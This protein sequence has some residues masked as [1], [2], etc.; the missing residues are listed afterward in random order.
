MGSSPTSKK[1]L[2]KETAKRNA[3]RK[4]HEAVAA[5]ALSD[6][7]DVVFEAGVKF[8]VNKSTG[9]A[10]E[11]NPFDET[12]KKFED[13]LMCQP[14][15]DMEALSPPIATGM[16]AYEELRGE[17]HKVMEFLDGTSKT[18]E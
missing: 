2:L 9:E 17:F 8:Y 1:Q 11:E 3:E 13:L 10:T 15:L 5:P 4:A 18:Y 6:L 7:W 12:P 16:V 14:R